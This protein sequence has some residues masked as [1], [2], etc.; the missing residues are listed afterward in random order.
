MVKSGL[1][2]LNCMVVIQQKGVWKVEKVIN[3][4]YYIIIE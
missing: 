1:V 3:N 2:Y 4:M